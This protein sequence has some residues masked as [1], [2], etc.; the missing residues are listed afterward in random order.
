MNE[1]NAISSWTKHGHYNLAL[2]RAGE[3]AIALPGQPIF[4]DIDC[5]VA[6]YP[7]KTTLCLLGINDFDDAIELIDKTNYDDNCLFIAINKFDYQ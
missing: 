7:G 2:F 6:W 4:P 3:S 1:I 5:I